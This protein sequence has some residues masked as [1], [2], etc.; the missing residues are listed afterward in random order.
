MDNIVQTNRFVYH[1]FKRNDL[2]LTVIFISIALLLHILN[3]A[4]ATTVPASF[5][6]ISGIRVYKDY[7]PVIPD[8]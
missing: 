5:V 4:T 6:A 3:L 8:H 1:V 2:Q 7:M